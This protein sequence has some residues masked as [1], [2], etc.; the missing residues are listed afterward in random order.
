MTSNE[1]K[2]LS[3]KRKRK[4]DRRNKNNIDTKLIIIN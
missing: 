2:K 4:I 1:N 3:R